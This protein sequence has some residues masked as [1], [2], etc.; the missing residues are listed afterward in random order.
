MYNDPLKYM[1]L[2]LKENEAKSCFPLYDLKFEKIPIIGLC[3][4]FKYEILN[5]SF[6][7]SYPYPAEAWLSAQFFYEFPEP[8]IICISCGISLGMWYSWGPP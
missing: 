6:L 5:V 8:A 2:L 7:G 4:I 1:E 3:F